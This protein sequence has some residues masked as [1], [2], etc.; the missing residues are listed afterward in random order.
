MNISRWCSDHG[1]DSAGDLPGVL[2]PRAVAGQPDRVGVRLGLRRGLG[3]RHL[4]LRRHGAAHVRQGIRGG[5]LQGARRHAARRKGLNKFQCE[6]DS[7]TWPQ[8]NQTKPPN[9]PPTSTK[10]P[11][12][13]LTRMQYSSVAY[14]AWYSYCRPSFTKTANR[15]AF[16]FVLWLDPRQRRKT[17]PGGLRWVS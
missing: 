8:P 4:P 9:H 6:S 5:L 15:I 12:R 1:V 17:N 16:N 13:T 11:K 7:K 14:P 3:R 2:R 10:K